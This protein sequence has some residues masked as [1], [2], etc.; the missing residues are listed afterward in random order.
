M[1]KRRFVE[2]GKNILIILLA[3]SAVYLLTMTPL[4]QDGGLAE[5]FSRTARKKEGNAVSLSAAALPSCMAVMGANGRYGLQYDQVG[6][7]ALFADCAPLLG[8]GLT[9]AEGPEEISRRQWQ[10][11]LCADSIFFDFDSIIPLSA[12][13]GWLQ[14]EGESALEGAARRI[15][16]AK[17]ENDGV[18]LCYEDGETGSFYACATGLSYSLHLKPLVDNIEGNDARFVFEEEELSR[19]LY[20]YSLIAEI[21]AG[22]V[23]RVESPLTSAATVEAVL[24]ALSF[25]GENHV[26][27]SDGE[28]YLDGDARLEVTDGSSMIYQGGQQSKY[29]VNAA[30]GEATVAELIEAARRLTNDTIGSHCGQARI[31]LESVRETED[32]FLVCFGYRLNGSPVWLYDDGWAAR[33]LIEDDVI[34]E[35]TLNFRSYTSAGEQ[36]PLLPME[37]AALILPDGKENLQE[38]TVCYFDGGGSRVTPSWVAK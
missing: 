29:P 32:G 1:D 2:W 9:S 16:L 15:L 17:G 21:T 27:V 20:P 10:E 26:S 4:V 11:Y 33:F 22:D 5:L 36:F 25:S 35:F 6:V 24:E 3:V 14:S 13:C 7:E 12:L 30:G 34:T 8:E 37:R 31:Y 18:L 23:Y 28:A 19:L 38:L